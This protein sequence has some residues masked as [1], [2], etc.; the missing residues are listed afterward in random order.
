VTV[1]WSTAISNKNPINNSKGFPSTGQEVK[2][3]RTI[4]FFKILMNILG[5]V[6]NHCYRMIHL[7]F[8]STILSKTKFFWITVAGQINAKLCSF[9]LKTHERKL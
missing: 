7:P 3:N 8:Y 6:L 9:S 2:D 4:T 5:S 1:Q